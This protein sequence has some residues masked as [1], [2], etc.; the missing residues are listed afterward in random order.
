MF[1]LILALLKNWGLDGE[2]ETSGKE[3]GNNQGK[4]EM[5]QAL[6]RVRAKQR[7]TLIKMF[8]GHILV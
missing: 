6:A 4:F 2:A 5:E 8:A 3:K 1:R 7:E